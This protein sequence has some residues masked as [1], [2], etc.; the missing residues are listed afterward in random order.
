[1]NAIV[2]EQE[3]KRTILEYSVFQQRE[4]DLRT[5]RNLIRQLALEA[6]T[7]SERTRLVLEGLTQF[8]NHPESEMPLERH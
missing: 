7:E 4:Q 5:T 8:I 2:Q 6:A 3:R 1:M